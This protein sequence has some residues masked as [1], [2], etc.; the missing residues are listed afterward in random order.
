MQGTA[1]EALKPGDEA[2][3]QQGRIRA[4]TEKTIGPGNSRRLA[5]WSRNPS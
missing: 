2:P 5:H 4:G 1:A 3:M